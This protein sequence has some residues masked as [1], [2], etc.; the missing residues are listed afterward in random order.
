MLRRNPRATA[1]KNKTK[2]IG[3][4]PNS[5]WCAELRYISAPDGFLLFKFGL[6]ESTVSAHSTCT[7]EV[8]PQYTE[9][10]KRNTQQKQSIC[11]GR[12]PLKLISTQVNAIKMYPLRVTHIGKAST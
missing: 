12:A 5:S 2:N 9:K 1:G 11:R 4:S 3:I 8:C 7:N 6:L 10:R